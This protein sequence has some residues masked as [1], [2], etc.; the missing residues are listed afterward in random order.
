M[1]TLSHVTGFKQAKNINRKPNFHSNN[2]HKVRAVFT[3]KLGYKEL[4]YN[5]QIWTSNRSNKYRS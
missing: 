1:F 2:Q 5:E 4:S 3:I